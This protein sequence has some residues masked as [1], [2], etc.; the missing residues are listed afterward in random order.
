MDATRRVKRTL[1]LSC[2]CRVVT[3]EQAA[4]QQFQNLQPYETRVFGLEGDNMDL[5]SRWDRFAGLFI[6]LMAVVA[7][8][9]CQAIPSS[10]GSTPSGTVSAAST[11]LDFGTAVVGSTTEV[12]DTLTNRS[13]E[14]VTIS[15]AA[16][17]NS[18]F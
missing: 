10:S 18:S 5:S 15:S 4:G 9:G 2:D 17:S 11:N 1:R 8:V 3:K 16:S 12:T 14:T 6:L 13:S 7:I